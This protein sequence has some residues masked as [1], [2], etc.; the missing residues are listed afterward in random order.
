M[1]YLR[2]RAGRRGLGAAPYRARMDQ[3]ART[4][5][6]AVAI[7][8]PYLRFAGLFRAA[9][10]KSASAL[11][12]WAYTEDLHQDVGN[13]TL[14]FLQSLTGLNESE[15]LYQS[16]S[17]VLALAF[18]FAD[19]NRSKYGL[20]PGVSCYYAMPRKLLHFSACFV[21]L[22]LK[23][24]RVGNFSEKLKINQE[25]RKN[26][27]NWIQLDW[28]ILVKVSDWKPTIPHYRQFWSYFKNG[29]EQLIRLKSIYT[30]A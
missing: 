15:S 18:A 8:L 7:P 2:R 16:S 27:K 4:I 5:G 21:K 3:P 20:L 26:R 14:N 13:L 30:I 10:V 25:G 24:L 11:V 1:W 23:E 29:F 9:I 19:K 17:V 22:W 12:S 6:I 28:N